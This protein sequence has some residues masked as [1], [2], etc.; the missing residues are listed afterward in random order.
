[1]EASATVPR[2]LTGTRILFSLITVAAVIGG[3]LGLSR[4]QPE[5]GAIDVIY[6]ILQLFVLGNPLFDEPRVIPWFLNAARFALP[7]VT[8]YAI[9]ET[10]RIIAT[11][12]ARWL[13]RRVTYGHTVVAGETTLANA[14][15]SFLAK[16]GV[17][18]IQI[19]GPVDAVSLRD[20]GISRADELIACADHIQDPWVNLA[21]A[22]EA[23][24][25][26][27]NGRPLK[28]RAQVS[29]AALAFTARSLGMTQA[30]KVSVRFFNV[31]E[32]AAAALAGNEGHHQD[33][34]ILGL[35]EFG[36][37]LLVEL[38]RSWRKR[39]P[40]EPLNVT[41]VDEHASA[42]LER[43]TAT[44]EVIGE[45]CAI[46]TVDGTHL[47]AGNTFSRVYVCYQD[48]AKALNAALTASGL[49]P[50]ETGGLV[51]RLD[52][53]AGISRAFNGTGRL[54]DDMKGRLRIISVVDLASS[55]MVGDHGDSDEQ[56]ARAIHE[57]YLTQQLAH[58]VGM[59][60]KPAMTVWE[61]LS[62]DMR[63]ANRAQAAGIREKL[64]RIGCTIVVRDPSL[65]AF[66]YRDDE[67][68]QL[69]ILEHDRWMQDKIAAGWVYAAERNDALKHHNSMVPWEKL[70]EVEREKD[71]DAVRN[72]PELLAE[73]GLQPARLSR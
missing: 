13:K 72:V 42:R 62:E 12:Q 10:G 9:F 27:R 4:L 20:A 22:L 64:D 40:R 34:A 56:I 26:E 36:G 23:A 5:K 46:T 41:V 33:I 29:D 24:E 68:E 49:W 35:Q 50:S 16:Q 65:P 38:A 58:Q 32:L 69:A 63:D 19:A 70:S 57:R 7:A 6:G 31:E 45:T 39:Q 37:A 14:V 28:V 54:L 67:L 3:Y 71:R 21:I 1:M 73:V 18:V 17:N 52:R 53:L 15:V 2:L 8:A 30:T 59:G 11:E 61:E 44:H 48:E 47:P 25:I 43:L 60:S 51:V 55:A 66:S